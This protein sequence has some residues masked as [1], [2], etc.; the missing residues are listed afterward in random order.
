MLAAGAGSVQRLWRPAVDDPTANPPTPLPA[1]PHVPSVTGAGGELEAQLARLIRTWQPD[2][3]L[4]EP[5]DPRGDNP[6]A[7]AIN[8]AVLRAVRQAGQQRSPE[9]LDFELEP[10][11]VKKIYATL[12]DRALGTVSLTSAQ[13]IPAAGISLA[14]YVARSRGMI[15]NAYVPPPTVTRFQLLASHLPP[16]QGHRDIFS[17]LALRHASDARRP[18]VKPADADIAQLR[19]SAARQQMVQAILATAA[20]GQTPPAHLLA[21][22]NTLTRNMRAESAADVL[23]DLATRF[24][25]LGQWALASETWQMLVERH[26]ATPQAVL[27]LMQLVRITGSAELQ[28]VQGPAEARTVSATPRDLG[29]ADWVPTEPGGGSGGQRDKSAIGWGRRLQDS[30]YMAFARSDIRLALASAHRRGGDVRQARRIWLGI[31]RSRHTDAWWRSAA[32]ELWLTESGHSAST[33]SRAQAIELWPCPAIRRKPRLDANLDDPCWQPTADQATRTGSRS[34][35]GPGNRR[36]SPSTKVQLAHDGEFLYLAAVCAKAAGMDYPPGDGPRPRDARLEGQD[37]LDLLLDIDRDRSTYYRLTIDHRGWTHDAC[38]GSPAWNPSWY[39]A[40]RSDADSWTCEVAI[41][42]DQ[43]IA[44]APGVRD[45]W[46]V[47]LQRTL[48]DVGLQSWTR[49]ASVDIMPEG[50]GYLR[51]E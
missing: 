48:P 23:V 28:H 6:R 45:V 27:G 24:A 14:E 40:A 15:H 11:Q 42:F 30:D 35:S 8:Q 22:I 20:G 41:P 31:Q 36:D 34:L 1:R 50:F 13:L 51:F 19:R 33:N 38:C 17:G 7:H 12:P 21:Q 5:A 44:Q 16:G 43:L 49:P 26:P 9:P 18:Y 29:Q 3:I 2:V 46:A 47:G 32:G 37:R 10:W 4:T 39:V 25:Q